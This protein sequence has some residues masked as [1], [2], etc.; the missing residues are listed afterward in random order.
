MRL[1]VVFTAALAALALTGC[2]VQATP[3]PGET[4]GVPASATTS[5]P[6]P[7]PSPAAAESSATQ[8]YDP[9]RGLDA[10]GQDWAD[11]KIQAWLDNSGI[12]SVKGFLGAYKLM[13]SW[14]SPKPGHLSIH[15]DNSYRF[16]QDGSAESHEVSTDELRFMGRIMFESIGKKSP[17]LESVTFATENKQHSGTFSRARTGADPADREAWAEEK[18][19]QWLEAMNDTYESFCSANIKKIETYRDCI[20]TDPHAYIDS[21]SSPAIGELVV[22]LAPGIW[23]GN[24]YDTDSIPGVDFVSGNMMLKINSKAHGP[25]Q[26]ETLTVKVQGTEETSTEHKSEWTQ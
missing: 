3:P 23:Q 19:V 11:S 18:F 22:T 10:S 14:D 2:S 5:S 13:N 1:R 8:R 25:E 7:S 4:A 24:T 26:V 16:N 17:E 21:V 6:S 12:K 9:A 20:P 15:L